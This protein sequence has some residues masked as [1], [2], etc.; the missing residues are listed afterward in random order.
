MVK[1]VPILEHLDQA[2]CDLFGQETRDGGKLRG[3]APGLAAV[4]AAAAQGATS[5][6]SCRCR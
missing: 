2:F 4:Q 3:L 1:F 6:A 5:A